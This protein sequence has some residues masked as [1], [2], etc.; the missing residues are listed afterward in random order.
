MNEYWSAVAHRMVESLGVKPEDL[1]LLKDHAGRLDA[2]QEALLAIE[3][4]GGTPLVEIAPPDYLSHYLNA[5][6]PVL[7]E[8]WD[9]HRQEWVR[10]AD[11][12]LVL[13]RSSGGV[14]WGA[15]P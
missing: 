7:L 15:L 14:G 6:A 4:S 5:A 8:S 11:R 13:P 12:L 9:Q 10:R 3:L 1:V 2:L